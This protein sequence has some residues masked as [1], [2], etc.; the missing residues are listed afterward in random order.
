MKKHYLIMLAGVLLFFACNDKKQSAPPEIV[1]INLPQSA[2]MADSMQ[3]SVTVDS[4]L[5]MSKIQVSFWYGENRISEQIVPVNTSGDIETMLYVPLAQDMVDGPAEVRVMAMN[6]NFDYATDMQTIEVVR[7]RFP[8]LTLKTMYGEFRM[9][10]IEG[11]PYTYAVNGAFPTQTLSGIIEAPVSGDNGNVVYFGGIP[12][13]ANSVVPAD[14]VMFV[15]DIPLGQEYTV[16]FN[17]LTYAYEPFVE[18][19]F[20]GV[21]FSAFDEAGMALAE[22]DLEQNQTIGI[23]GFLDIADWWIDPTFIDRAGDTF[24]FRAVDGKYRVTADRGLKYFRIEP[25]NGDALADFD[26]ETK[27]GGVWVN[28]GVGSM[29]GS[30]PVGRLGIPSTASNPTLWDPAKNFAMAPMGGGIYELKLIASETMFQSNVSGS[31]V[32]ISFYENSRSKDAAFAL[33]LV[34]TLYGSPGVPETS[35]GSARFEFNAGN[36]DSN[37]NMIVSGSNRSLGA[38]RTYVFTLD[39]NYSPAQVSISL[40]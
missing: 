38:H 22:V 9:E 34:Q 1:S 20:A 2:N 25:M 10:P 19:E 7:P 6:K 17:T 23:R 35:G 36:A 33:S 16:S 11:E 27:T 29:A 24:E 26:P 3:F 14:S 21:L 5:P 13:S 28:G 8:Y 12:V 18:P 15:T 40:E 39:T 32:G 30:A 31:N 4:D 37:G